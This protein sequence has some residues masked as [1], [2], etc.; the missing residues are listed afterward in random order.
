LLPV[1]ARADAEEEAAPAE[2]IEGGDLL[3][4]EEWIALRDQRDAG[5]EL[6]RRRHP[7]GARESDEGIDEVRVALGD[8][9]VGGAGEAARRLHGH[10]WM[11]GTPERLEAEGLGGAGHERRIDVLGRKRDRHSNV[12][13]DLP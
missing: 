5:A 2:V 4:E 10:D 9:A 11:L 8:D 6:Q 1:P 12:H 7:R 3:R 13:A